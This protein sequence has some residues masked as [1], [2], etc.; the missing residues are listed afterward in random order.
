MSEQRMVIIRPEADVRKQVEDAWA[1]LDEACE[2]VA[3]ATLGEYYDVDREAFCLLVEGFVQLGV[4]VE[5]ELQDLAGV[6]PV[7]ET[8]S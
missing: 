5:Q 6:K 7:D 2:G 8:L 4:P 1:R 3:R